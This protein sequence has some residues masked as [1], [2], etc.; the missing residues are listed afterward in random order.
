MLPST[1]RE[2]F[3]AI[4]AGDACVHPASAFDPISARIAEDLGYEIGM[5]GGSIASMAVLGAPDIYVLTLSELAE[6]ARRICRASNLPLFVD[7]DHGYGN[8]L[9]VMRTVEELENA[10]VAALTIEDTKLPLSFGE[11]TK[12]SLISMEEG[13]GKMKAALAARRDPTLVIAGRTSAPEITG[14]DDTI[15]RCRAYEA[16]GVDTLFV[17]GLKIRA[18]LEKVAAAVRLPLVLDRLTPEIS[19]RAWLG[20]VRVRVALQGHPAYLAGMAGVHATLKALRDGVP[21][22][23]LPNMPPAAFGKQ[24]TRD[25]DYARWVKDFLGG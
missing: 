16:A 21:P 14:I 9:N 12:E 23:D 6:H 19:D 11:G 5:L 17:K 13:I 20:S 18:D 22:S 8:A 15:A 4:L 7:A 25:A 3:R 2:R 10:G 1:R 24:V